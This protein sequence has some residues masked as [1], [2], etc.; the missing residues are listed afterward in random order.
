MEIV[1]RLAEDRQPPFKRDVDD[2]AFVEA[3]FTEFAEWNVCEGRP[4]PKFNAGR[5]AP[6]HLQRCAVVAREIAPGVNRHVDAVPWRF[7]VDR[8]VTGEDIV[9]LSAKQ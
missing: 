7:I 4:C 6:R 2:D 8:H 3:S 9:M 1:R 5:E